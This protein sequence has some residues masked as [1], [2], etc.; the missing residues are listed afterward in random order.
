VNAA[1]KRDCEEKLKYSAVRLRRK[2][3]EIVRDA[4]VAAARRFKQK[5]HAI[6]VCLNH[7]HIVCE[8]VDVPIG[9]LTGYYKNAARVALKAEGFEGKVWTKGYDKRYCFDEKALFARIA[10]VEKHNLVVPEK[11]NFGLNLLRSN[12][13]AADIFV[14]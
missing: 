13:V 2:Q 11:V 12:R 9:V 3:K 7:V 6:A 1:L 8:Y 10:Y 4:F 5:I 14:F